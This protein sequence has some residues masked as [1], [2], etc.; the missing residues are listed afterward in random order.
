MDWDLDERAYEGGSGE[1]A[2]RRIAL[3]CADPA[4]IPPALLP[5]RER[6]LNEWAADKGMTREQFDR[7]RAERAQWDMR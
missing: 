1:A 4:E 2:G 3:V 6:L 7:Y 5:L